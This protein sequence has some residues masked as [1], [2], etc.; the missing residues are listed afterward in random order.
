MHEIEVKILE[1]DKGLITQTLEQIGANHQL[2]GE[3]LAVFY[4]FPDGQIRSRGDV[5]RL[6][7][8]VDSQVLTYKKYISKGEAKIM[9]ELETSFEDRNAMQEIITSLGLI[10]IKKTRK[11]RTQYELGNTHI[12]IDEYMDDL[13]HIPPF[14]EVEAPN[15]TRLEEV[16]T[17]LGFRMEDCKSWDTNDLQLHYKHLTETKPGAS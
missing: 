14:I 5:F 7:Q 13:S 6:R 2:E 9:E 16:V 15:V 12:V 17:A 3:F 8:E 1:I 11:Y 4:D 10:T